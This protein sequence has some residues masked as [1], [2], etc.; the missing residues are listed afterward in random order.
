MTTPPD[1]DELRMQARLRAAFDGTPR[2]RPRDW[3]DDLLDETKTAPAAPPAPPAPPAKT[4]TAAEDGPRW[5]WRA[6]AHWSHASLTCGACAALAPVFGGQSAATGWGGV[7]QQ[8]REQAGV[9]A[10][11]VIASVGLTVGA[12]FVHRRRSWWAWALLTSAFI[13]TVAMASPMD[14]IQFVT[15]AQK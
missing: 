6:L 5:N 2:S 3:L 4:A 1:E 15:G 10:A 13:G 11:W 12:V 9:G 8:A 7:L 14:I